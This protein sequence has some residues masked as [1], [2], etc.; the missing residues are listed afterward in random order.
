MLLVEK[1]CVVE[2][3]EVSFSGRWKLVECQGKF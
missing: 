2:E 1:S 3:T